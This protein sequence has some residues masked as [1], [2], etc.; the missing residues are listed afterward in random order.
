ML[1]K[2]AALVVLLSLLQL[3]LCAED[4]YKV[5]MPSDVLSD[6]LLTFRRSSASTGLP[7]TSN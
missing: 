3:A 2:I 5:G 7:P 6:T 4:F 1:A